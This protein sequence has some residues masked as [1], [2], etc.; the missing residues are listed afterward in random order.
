MKFI[1]RYK[2]GAGSGNHGHAGRPGHQGGSAAGDGSPWRNADGTPEGENQGNPNVDIDTELNAAKIAYTK[3]WNL[4][5]RDATPQ[6]QA[7][8]DAAETKLL[9][10]QKLA[11]ERPISE[12]FGKPK[13]AQKLPR[14]GPQRDKPGPSP[15]DT[16]HEGASDDEL[17]A[18][19]AKVAKKLERAEMAHG[20]RPSGQTQWAVDQARAQMDK[21]QIE[22]SRRAP[23]AKATPKASAFSFMPKHT[24]DLGR[25]IPSS[26]RTGEVSNERLRLNKRGQTFVQEYNQK[27]PNNKIGIRE[28]DGTVNYNDLAY[29]IE[30]LAR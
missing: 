20:K 27:F 17:G 19:M 14:G 13:P 25:Y 22:A 23:K 10:L 12:V 1:I 11:G 3:A 7:K 24:T 18:K 5:V 9:A 28:H 16:G 2:G 30:K 8:F 15:R 29:A 6:S 21:L 4:H 26:E